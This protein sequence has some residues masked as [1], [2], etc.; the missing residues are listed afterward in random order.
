M[1]ERE[2][3]KEVDRAGGKEGGMTG[4][5]NEW[6]EKGER[7][8]ERERE[9]GREGEKGELYITHSLSRFTGGGTRRSVLAS[10]DKW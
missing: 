7:Q 10:I 2:R 8:R 4:K 6:I 5:I 9:I 3:L 1:R